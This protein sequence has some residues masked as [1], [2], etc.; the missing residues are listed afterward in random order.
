MVQILETEKRKGKELQL[1]ALPKEDIGFLRG[2]LRISADVPITGV[3]FPWK[4]PGK[5]GLFDEAKSEI[6]NGLDSGVAGVGE[7]FEIAVPEG[8]S[9]KSIRARRIQPTFSKDKDFLPRFNFGIMVDDEIRVK[10]HEVGSF[11]AG[12]AVTKLLC[13]PRKRLE[14]AGEGKPVLLVS[15]FPNFMTG[16]TGLTLPLPQ[17]IERD[18]RLDVISS[19]EEDNSLVFRSIRRAL[20][21]NVTEESLKQFLAG[22]KSV[23]VLTFPR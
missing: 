19:C 7:S 8:F 11:T 3:V 10:G 20:Y 2:W 18:L 22:I 17:R 9:A 5:F 15:Y 12:N 1:D 6:Q 21:G 23:F 16:Q 4:P 14:Q 13:V